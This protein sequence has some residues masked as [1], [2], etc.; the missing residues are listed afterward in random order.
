MLNLPIRFFFSLM[1]A[2]AGAD[3]V[4]AIESSL[5]MAD[6]CKKVID[7]HK[8]GIKII[9]HHSTDEKAKESLP[10]RASL[11]VSET[12]DCAILGEKVLDTLI[13][14]KMNLLSDSGK[15]IP[16]SAQFY[17]CGIEANYIRLRNVVEN[18][19]KDLGMEELNIVN[20]ETYDN[21]YSFYDAECLSTIPDG[22]TELT[23]TVSC[24]D[25]NFNC[26]KDMENVR[27]GKK[28]VFL[29]LV[30]K[31]EGIFDCVFGWFR[32]QLDEEISIETKPGSSV[33]CWDQAVFPNFEPFKVYPG[34]E[35]DVYM[36]F[37]DSKMKLAFK[38]QLPTE[39]E[40]CLASEC[41]I[42]MLNDKKFVEVLKKQAKEI[43]AMR[44]VEKVLDFSPFPVLGL[45]VLRNRG[46]KCL[47]CGP[48]AVENKE[49]I[50]NVAKRLEV[51]VNFFHEGEDNEEVR[52][53][54]FDLVHLDAINYNG[55]LNENVFSRISG[56]R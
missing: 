48:K 29:K 47:I 21:G 19:P 26:L 23:E 50:E 32:L 14:A 7:H 12:L 49:L 42:T 44:N 41:A 15:I 39:K 53:D 35:I 1:A 27:N 45:S 54:G 8:A 18:A 13:H 51:E 6:I 52:R 3:S 33:K 38:K 11:I 9:S 24:L 16:Q 2:D 17:I 28:D 56:L 20:C 5:P 46:G 31:K 10:K 37:I 43:L 55:E 22:Y 4:Y 25:V 34:D 40:T 30:V 36:T